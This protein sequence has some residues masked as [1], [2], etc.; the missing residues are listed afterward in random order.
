VV[1]INDKSLQERLLMMSGL[2]KTSALEACRSKAVISISKQVEQIQQPVLNT[3]PNIVVIRHGRKQ[4][5]SQVRST[6]F[7]NNNDV[8]GNCKY[9]GLEHQYGH[10]PAF[11]KVCAKCKGK[12]HF[13]RYV[14]KLKNNLHFVEEIHHSGD[15]DHMDS[16]LIDSI[17][18]SKS[19]WYTV[20][21]VILSQSVE[22]KVDTGAVCN[23]MGLPQFKNLGFSLKIIKKT[24]VVLRSFS[25]DKILVIGKESL[26]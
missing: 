4:V 23:V 25:K 15:S 14:V 11:G 7:P 3:E 18:V 20:K 10:C 2:T 6:V 9:C 21:L 19:F 24:N 5:H 26:V 12:N 13:E 22:Y 8:N 1:G 16:V 17:T